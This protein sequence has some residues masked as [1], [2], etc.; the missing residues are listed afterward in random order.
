MQIKNLTQVSPTEVQ[1]TFT[2][3]D[4]LLKATITCEQE[5]AVNFRLDDELSTGES[6]N[7]ATL[8]LP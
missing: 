5:G 1:I 3:D 6:Y 2:G 4:M 7:L 8:R